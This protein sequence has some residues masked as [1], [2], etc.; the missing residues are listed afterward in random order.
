MAFYLIAL[1]RFD[2]YQYYAGFPVTGE[3]SLYWGVAVIIFMMSLIIILG[4]KE[5]YQPS[6]LRGE[7][8]TFR[9]F[10]GG[11]LNRNL[12]PVYLLIVGWIVANAGLGSLGALLYTEQ[13]GFTKQEMGINVAVGTSINVFLIILIGIFA[14]KLPRMK[15]F[16]LLLFIS[17]LIELSYYIYVEFILFDKTPSLPE[18]IIF[19]EM[20]SIAG[21]ILGMIYVP[22]V[23]DYVPRN[24]MGTFVAG[25]NI[26]HQILKVITL[27]GIGVFITLYASFFM[28]PGG[29]MVRI[30]MNSVLDKAVIEE[31]LLGSESALSNK[32]ALSVETY[33][34]TNAAWDTGRAFEIRLKNKPVL[35]LKERAD[36]LT[37]ELQSILVK[38][39]NAEAAAE[40]SAIAGDEA[41]RQEALAEAQKYAVEAEPYET[42]IAGI[43]ARLAESAQTF[44]ERIQTILGPI[45]MESG[46]Q[47]VDATT[48]QATLI[49][50]P[51]SDRPDADA[52][53]RTVNQLRLVRP[54]LIDLRLLNRGLT[55]YLEASLLGIHPEAAFADRFIGDFHSIAESRMGNSLPAELKPES[56]RVADAL[57]LE[58]LTIEDP[59]N[60]HISP[61]TKVIYGIWDWFG[62][63]PTPERR[64]WATA[65]ALR[66]LDET[67]HVGIW[68]KS[69]GYDYAMLIRAV[70]AANPLHPENGFP[71]LS[72]AEQR[73]QALLGAEE[74][75]LATAIS[76]YRR[77]V[78]AVAANKLTIPAP[79]L[80]ARFAPQ[81][82][83]YMSGYLW[84][85]FMSS[86]GLVICMLFTRRERKGLIH[87]RGREESE[88]EAKAEKNL[89]ADHPDSQL[90][91]HETYK[92]GYVPYKILMTLGG[93]GMVSFGLIELAP[94]LRLM[95]TGEPATAIASRVVKERIGGSATS[96]A[97]DA[98]ILAAKERFDR[99]YVFW[100]YFQF[101]DRNGSVVEFRAN[102]GKQLEPAYPLRDAD[103]LPTTIRIFF[104]PESPQ[105]AVIPGSYSTWFLSG[106]LVL[107]GSAGTV[108]GALLLY[109]ARKPIAMPVIANP[110]PEP[111]KT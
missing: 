43:E 50:I 83:D 56:Q 64:I 92:P 45:M 25:R 65:R 12:W 89:Q 52:L 19:G 14:D 21:I 35:A 98:D 69:N 7:R 55:F 77:A 76:L 110:E 102:V 79:V 106:L 4:V 93:L 38:K 74:P 94:T 61:I 29:D 85:I 5:T 68:D 107:F 80:D 22:L 57:S 36:A 97:S 31:R 103:G 109:Y 71:E 3:Q 73:I 18:V 28:P 90:E 10:F 99:S 66:D 54:D 44:L 84:M 46:A 17:I 60:N 47:V 41:A 86:L 23:F 34:A 72:D 11:L 91:G 87:K 58:L 108:F 111:E 81:K 101:E 33:Y 53:R 8:L 42:E 96:L 27:N 20:A 39:S 16:E 49:E 88:R 48:E 15:T 104:N 40:S 95:A 30:T 1:G 67:P 2:D 37:T 70:P 13:W 6:K 105:D 59:I 63:P 82:Y 26:T 78:E 24:E 9:S 51:L 75:L 62:D 32:D 100:N